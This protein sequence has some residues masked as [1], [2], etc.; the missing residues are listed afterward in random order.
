MKDSYNMAIS[1]SRLNAIGGKEVGQKKHFARELSSV[2]SFLFTVACF[3]AIFLAEF[4]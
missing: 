3:F 1:T 4:Q 2:T